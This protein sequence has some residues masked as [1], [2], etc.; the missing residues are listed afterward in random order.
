MLDEDDGERE[1]GRELSGEGTVRGG[2]EG[3]ELSGEG[4][5]RGGTEERELSGEGTVRGGNCGKG[6]A[7]GSVGKS[8]READEEASG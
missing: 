8:F 3:R 4:T 5:V 6:D 2:T 1:G 7:G